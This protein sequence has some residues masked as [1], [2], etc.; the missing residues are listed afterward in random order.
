MKKLLIILFAGVALA[1][2]SNSE[3]SS[4]A[5]PAVEASAP[6]TVVEEASAPVAEASAPAAVE[7]TEASAAQ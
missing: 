6:A 2:C 5:T 1:G 4:E 7:N 3:N